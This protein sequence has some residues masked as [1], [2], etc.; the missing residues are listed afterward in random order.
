MHLFRNSRK[1]KFGTN[2]GESY[3]SPENTGEE[4]AFIVKKEETEQGYYSFSMTEC[5]DFSWI[6]LLLGK[7]KYPWL[8]AGVVKH[9]LL[10]VG[11]CEACFLWQVVV[12]KRFS[13]RAS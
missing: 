13:F 3:T 6:G 12:L 5:G 1:L 7:E 4:L 9:R 2:F 8:L 10:P 11:H